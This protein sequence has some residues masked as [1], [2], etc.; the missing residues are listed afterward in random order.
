M[1][2]CR[3]TSKFGRD[4]GQRKALYKGLANSVIE[5]EKITTTLAKAKVM[6]PRVERLITLAKIDNQHNRRLAFKKLQRKAIVTRLFDTI[7]PRFKDRPGGYLRIIKLGHRAGDGAEM[8]QL[9][10]V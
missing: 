4:S 9:E 3:V 8:A 5:H 6:K 7:G 2:H 10:M 1:R